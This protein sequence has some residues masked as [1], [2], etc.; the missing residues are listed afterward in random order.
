[1]KSEKLYRGQGIQSICIIYKKVFIEINL[2]V[3]ILEN[4]QKVVFTNISR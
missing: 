2:G 4:F 3:N 1:M